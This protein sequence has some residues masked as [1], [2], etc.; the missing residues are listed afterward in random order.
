MRFRM[1]AGSPTAERLDDDGVSRLYFCAGGCSRTGRTANEKAGLEKI[2]HGA[3]LTD[4][5]LANHRRLWMVSGIGLCLRDRLCEYSA[6]PKWLMRG[7]VKVIAGIAVAVFIFAPV[8]TSTGM[9][10]FVGSIVLLLVCFGVLKLSEADDE[11]TGHW[12]QDPKQ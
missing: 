8:T 6:V 3:E 11:N 5:C 4:Y 9:L 2:R 7:V 1:V 10:F 12:P